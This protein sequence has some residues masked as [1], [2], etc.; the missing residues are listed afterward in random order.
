M[1][2]KH[3]EINIGKACNNKCKFCMSSQAKKSDKIFVK[4]EL[5]KKKVDFYEENGYKSIGFLGGDISIYPD[6]EEIIL[7]CRE[8]N[9]RSINIIS[10][11]MRFDDIGF[12]TKIVK[13]GSTRFN[14]S[15]HSHINTI[16]DYLT[17]VPGGLKRKLKA[18][19]NLNILIQN[20]LL[21]SPLSINMV[22]N[23]INYE[24]IT[25]S[26]L[27]FFYKKNIKDIR[28]N[29]I[30]L[31][32]DIEDNRDKLKISYTEFLPYLKKLIY[33][34]FKKDIRITFDAIPLCI[35]FKLGIQ[36][37]ESIIKKF[38]GEDKDYITSVDNIN[39]SD[40]FNWVERKKNELK[41]K[42]KVCES[43]KYNHSCQGVWKEYKEI[44]GDGEFG[45]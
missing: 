2:L 16:E 23:K 24:T 38:V 20:G 39:T 9:F 15:I 14:I 10:N 17:S 19:D 13:A 5:L 18:I 27:Y 31:S 12:L 22:I 44:Y 4:K 3:I 33:I 42:L 35:F 21:N 41:T 34:S 36:D 43:C 25:E 1:N 7:Y 40:E 28:I 8:K 37:M 45:I 6:L 29:F 32:E 11:S 26:V 30:W